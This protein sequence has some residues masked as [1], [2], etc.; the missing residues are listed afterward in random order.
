MSDYC[1]SVFVMVLTFADRPVAGVARLTGAAVAS[2]HV[3][4]QGVLIAVV[5]PAETLVML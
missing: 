2:H 5:E 3:E 4:A 1:I